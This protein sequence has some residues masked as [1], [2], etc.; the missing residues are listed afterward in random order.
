MAAK[1]LGNR[2][3]AL[4]V[5]PPFGDLKHGAFISVD[6]TM[7]LLRLVVAAIMHRKTLWIKKKFAVQ[8]IFAFLEASDVSVGGGDR[9]RFLSAVWLVV[10]D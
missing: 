5:V 8:F 7:Y 10:V 4:D 2:V 1:L 3:L 9:G 6:N